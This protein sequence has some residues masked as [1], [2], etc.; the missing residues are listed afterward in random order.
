[1]V[2]RSRYSEAGNNKKRE[3]WTV[4]HCEWVFCCWC[5]SAPLQWHLIYT[6]ANSTFSQSFDW[7][8]LRQ[9][10]QS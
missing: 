6:G 8:R 10:T 2:F 9:S 1:M 4:R 7:Q 5:T 3:K